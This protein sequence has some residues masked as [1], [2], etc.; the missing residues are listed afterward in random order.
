MKRASFSRRKDRGKGEAPSWLFDNIAE[1]SKHTRTLHTIYIGFLV[2]CV[3]STF[4]TSDKKILLNEEAHL[5]IINA[6]VRLSAFV[7]IAPV[8]A[9]IIFVY[10][11]FHFQMLKEM[12]DELRT[13]YKPMHKMR[14]SP[15]FMFMDELSGLGILGQLN[16]IFA[17]L[18]LWLLLLLVLLLFISLTL[19]THNFSLSLS[20]W[21]LSCI[22]SLTVFLFWFR[23][24][25]K[26]DTRQ[27]NERVRFA[28][29]DVVVLSEYLKP[30]RGKSF[31][32]LLVLLI[33]LALLILILNINRLHPSFLNLNLSEQSLV[34]DHKGDSRIYWVYLRQ[35]E[36]SGAKLEFSDLTRADLVGANLQNASAGDA[37]FTSANLSEVNFSRAV[38][39]QADL[40]SAVLYK[41]DMSGA[42]LNCADL[43]KADFKKANL[44]GAYLMEADLRQARNLTIEQLSGVVTL[45]HTNLDKDLAEQIDKTYP[46]LREK[47]QFEEDIEKTYA[48]DEKLIKDGIVFFKPGDTIPASRRGTL[49]G[50]YE[51]YMN[52]LSTVTRLIRFGDNQIRRVTYIYAWSSRFGRQYWYLIEYKSAPA[53]APCLE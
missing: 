46:N 29:F 8:A 3:L 26:Q 42:N 22:G 45:Y 39:T 38:L 12:I 1:L 6:D 41:A 9:I 18:T 7:I 30:H 19:R 25:T 4:S 32:G 53:F 14:L 28:V 13:T 5:P 35:A 43:S 49:T 11:Q 10:F 24:D 51:E 50:E 31:I 16:R 47:P 15:W 34:S 36:L 17:Q 37:V 27:P 21:F 33:H 2:Y 23:Y 52:V 48:Y 20:E 44:S 40:Q